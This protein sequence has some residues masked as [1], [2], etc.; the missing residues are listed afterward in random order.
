MGELT[1]TWVN[2]DRFSQELCSKVGLGDGRQRKEEGPSILSVF[3]G[4][5]DEREGEASVRIMSPLTV[6]VFYFIP[7]NH[8]LSD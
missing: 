7:F 3:T 1:L 4:L 2:M 6:L 8:N 5:G